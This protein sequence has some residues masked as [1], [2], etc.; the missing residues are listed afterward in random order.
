[1]ASAIL[2]RHI[3]RRLSLLTGGVSI[4]NVGADTEVELKEKQD[5]VDDA[6]Q[7]VK[8][9]RK[10][11]ILPGGGAAL[12]FVSRNWSS[13]LSSG[14]QAG[15]NILMSA[16]NAP[17]EKILSNAGLDY[18]DFEFEKW[19]QGVDVT[20]GKI[21]DMRKTGIIDPV[22]VTKQALRNAVSVA[23]TILSTDAV[24]SNVREL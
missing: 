9:A 7:A 4:I 21:K 23:V 3:E 2:S 22:M 8:A 16:I 10:E 15:W 20:D 11:G 12:R 14:E 24:I 19:G 5:R 17:Y 18:Y 13:S 6:V 1:M